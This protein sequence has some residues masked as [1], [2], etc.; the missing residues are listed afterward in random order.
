MEARMRL[1]LL[2]PFAAALVTTPALGAAIG[3]GGG[4][5]AGTGAIDRNGGADLVRRI[6]RELDRLS[7]G[8]ELDLRRIERAR[9]PGEPAAPGA[10][11]P[12]R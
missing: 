8:L 12:S 4:A 6:E 9:R 3:N 7:R 10:S 11:S 1:V 5:G 2:V